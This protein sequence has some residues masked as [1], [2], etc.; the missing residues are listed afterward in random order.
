MTKQRITTITKGFRW[1]MF[2]VGLLFLGAMPFALGQRGQQGI[3]QKPSH[4]ESP[5]HADGA[6]WTFTGSLNTARFLH[7]ATLLPNG[8]VLVAGGLDNGFHATSSSE[9]Y[10]PASG[11]WTATGN[12]S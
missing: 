9:L 10:D 11:I 8:V 6:T 7:T 4:V 5:S 3:S 12:L 2:F 1:G